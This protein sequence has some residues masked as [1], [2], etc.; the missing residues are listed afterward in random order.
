MYDQ[1]ENGAVRRTAVCN[2][3]KDMSVANHGNN[4]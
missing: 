1:Q 4:I 2:S 3:V